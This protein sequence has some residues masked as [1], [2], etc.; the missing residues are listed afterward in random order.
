[1]VAANIEVVFPKPCATLPLDRAGNGWTSFGPRDSGFT[2]ELPILFTFSFLGEAYTS[3]N[4]FNNG[5]IRLLG[6]TRTAFVNGWLTDI[7]TRGSASGLV[8]YKA[9]GAN[10]FAAAWDRVGVYPSND[11]SPNTFQI[12]ISDGTNPDMGIGNKICLCYKNM[13]SVVGN[14]VVS[15]SNGAGMSFRVGVFD[16]AGTDYDGFGDTSAGWDYLDNKSFCYKE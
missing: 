15:F 13:G 8:W 12:M 6:G 1:L 7:D 11:N 14:A 4:V 5:Y 2:A 9:I 16:H 10:T 3:L